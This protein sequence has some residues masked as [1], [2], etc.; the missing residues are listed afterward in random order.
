M[1]TD[2]LKNI[3]LD[4][5]QSRGYS[6]S[7]AEQIINQ[8]ISGGNKNVSE[9]LPGSNIFCPIDKQIK[10]MASFRRQINEYERLWR[11]W[12]TRCVEVQRSIQEAIEPFNEKIRDINIWKK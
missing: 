3:T 5:L 10:C 9:V 12:M 1:K 8:L 11:T 4:A 6:Q 2:K 7:E